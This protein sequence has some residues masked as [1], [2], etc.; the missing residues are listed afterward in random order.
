MYKTR[1]I[2]LGLHI[3]TPVR[4]RVSIWFGLDMNYTFYATTF[5]VG[6]K[7]KLIDVQ[8]MRQTYT[9]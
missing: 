2:K 7:V 8:T 9:R 4:V 3:V 6:V 1:S 5:H